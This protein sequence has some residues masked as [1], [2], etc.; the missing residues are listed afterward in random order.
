MLFRKNCQVT[1]GLCTPKPKAAPRK[2]PAKKKPPKRKPKKKSPPKK[3]PPKKKPPK[4]NEK[5]YRLFANNMDETV[6]PCND[7]YRFT[8][9]NYIKKHP[10]NSP[11]DNFATFN[12]L[13]ANINAQ[14]TALLFDNSTSSSSAVKKMRDFRDKCMKVDDIE[15]ARTDQL[16][17]DLV[18][19][20]FSLGFKKQK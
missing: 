19:S 10:A 18:V 8:C 15:K 11:T 6:N 17:K 13:E 3:K 9:G 2:S 1:C 5:K 14:Q 7:F 4:K 20:L 16:R 12:D